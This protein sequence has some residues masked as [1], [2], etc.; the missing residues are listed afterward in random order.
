MVC[1]DNAKCITV[2]FGKQS[3]NKYYFASIIGFEEGK[4]GVRC[5][6]GGLYS[7]KIHVA[8]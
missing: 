3:Y 5:G 7:I 8:G 4:L 1:N 6:N 2:S